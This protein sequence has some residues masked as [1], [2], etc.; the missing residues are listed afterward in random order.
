MAGWFAVA[1]TDEVSART[2]LI[3]KVMTTENVFM[4]PQNDKEDPEVTPEILRGEKKE[5]DHLTFYYQDQN[6]DPQECTDFKTFLQNA[7]LCPYHK[8][9]M[10]FWPAIP[11]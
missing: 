8:A 4:F 10:G 6:D 11:R 7:K 9:L 2:Q 1:S 5:V 3:E